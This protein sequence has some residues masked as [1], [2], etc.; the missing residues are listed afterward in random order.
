L[1]TI[2]A[3]GKPTIL[4]LGSSDGPAGRSAADTGD[5]N[6]VS[7]L[8]EE[9]RRIGALQP[10]EDV[11]R[12]T[13]DAMT[14]VA[15][16]RVQWFAKS[17]PGCVSQSGAFLPRK[18]QHLALDGV[19]GPHFLAFLKLFRENRWQMTGNLVQIS[20]A[21]LSRM[22]PNRNYKAVLGSDHHI[23]VCD[24]EFSHVLRSMNSAAADF[25][26]HVFVNQLFRVE[27][28][29]V[30]GAVVPPASFSAHKIGRAVD[31]QLGTKGSIGADNPQL[32]TAIKSAV[33]GT[34]FY[35]FREYAKTNLLCRYGGDFHPSDPPHFD[36]QILPGGSESWKFHFFVNQ[37]H[38]RQ[39]LINAAAIASAS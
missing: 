6:S 32:S 20:F 8:Q 12:G 38:Y 36:R 23:G 16:R 3:S 4:H 27:G 22:K 39:A 11:R 13:F 31:L 17:V 33:A 19:A 29:A 34:P 14:K 5:L 35:K 1:A 24:R 25:G 21:G 26:V 7:G 9:L 37:L 28:H 10:N 30:S 15:V 2:A 18:P